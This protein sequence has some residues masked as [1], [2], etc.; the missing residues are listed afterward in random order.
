METTNQAG[1]DLPMVHRL[2]RFDTRA[3]FETGKLD[4]LLIV[5]GGSVEKSAERVVITS[6]P[7]KSFPIVG[8]WTSPEILGAFEFTELL[9]SWNVQTP[10]GALDTTG[11]RFDVRI[12]TGSE[13]S[14]WLYMGG[15]G[16]VP[17][18][19][20][21]TKFPGGK[22]EVDIVELKQ[23]AQAFQI[24]ATLFSFDLSGRMMPELRRVSACYSS[25]VA[26]ERERDLVSPRPSTARAAFGRDLP[27]PFRAQGA[28]SASISS[29]ICSPTSVSMVMEFSGVSRPTTAN[30]MAVY[31]AEYDLFGNWN[32]AVQLAGSLGLDSYLTRIST[33]DE[34]R[35]FVAAGQPVIASIR[36][37]KNEFPSNIMEDTD[38]HLIVI[39][40]FNQ[41]GDAIVNDPAS[42]SR[43]NGIIYKADELERA[44]I[45]S[46]GGIAY[47]IAPLG[48]LPADSSR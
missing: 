34:A 25:V 4:N 18:R 12:K 8:T 15:W 37:K 27:V 10:D 2:V 20:K 24:R 29:E 9:P 47:I 41:D 14:P 44:W 7:A 48:K 33:I 46:A 30:A 32:R 21:L 3:A 1:S 5:A 17:D 40:G 11:A 31:D 16:R 36:F 19:R 39:R 13:W 45:K 35:A 23:K 38:G 26:N 6:A 43:G 42:K 22:V 28:E